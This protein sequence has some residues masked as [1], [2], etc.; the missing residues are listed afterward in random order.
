MSENL[1]QIYKRLCNTSSDINEHL[2]TLAKYS[3]ECSHI[4]EMGVRYIVSTYALLM[5]KPKKMISYDIQMCNWEYV[6]DLVKENTDFQFYIGNTLEIEIEPTEL[7]FIDTL[8]NYTQLKQ[9]LELHAHKVSKYIIFH[10]TTSFENVGE[11][12]SGKPETGIW[13]AIQEFLEKNSQW[14]IKERFMNNNGLTV[15]EN[16]K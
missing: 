12:Y 3:S 4:T 9:E 14:V 6:R 8:H 15:I 11:S 10:D 1:N 16:L 2:P 5:G 7:L 13:P